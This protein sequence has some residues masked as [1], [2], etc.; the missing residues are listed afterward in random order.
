M[1]NFKK[2]VCLALIFV[3]CLSS[4]LFAQEQEVAE[5]A[6][7][8]SNEV[9]IADSPEVESSDVEF[10]FELENATEFEVGGGLENETTAVVG[11][12]KEVADGLVIGASIKTYIDLLEDKSSS[13]TE[14]DTEHFNSAYLAEG[15]LGGYVNLS[16]APTEWLTLNTGLG[17]EFNARPDD[18]LYGYRLGFG[19]NL[20]LEFEVEDH[21][22]TAAIENSLIPQWGLG[23]NEAKN[24]L[25]LNSFAFNMRYD[26]FN[27]LKEDLN[28]GLFT[29]LVVD[30]EN[31][32]CNFESA[33]QGKHSG[34]PLL[35]DLEY[36]LGLAYSPA[37]WVDI[38][39]AFA[40]FYC[41]EN[42]IA[43]AVSDREDKADVEYG[44][45]VGLDF[46][47]EHIGFGIG[48]RP[49]LASTDSAFEPVHVFDTVV[50]ISF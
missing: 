26:L 43:S 24:N 9:A 11:L 34:T 20:G 25:L 4:V 32:F 27:Y 41:V 31:Y 15:S 44:L 8:E 2:S 35:I 50:T 46:S 45:R 30:T 18:Y 38:S 12:N 29:E 39:A 17:I 13:I 37:D 48:Y 33:Q 23:A 21:F 14:G 6:S 19:W 1:Y 47:L 49:H 16:Y 40:L 7:V 42:D 10:S 28:L 3:L 5:S 22:L 36:F